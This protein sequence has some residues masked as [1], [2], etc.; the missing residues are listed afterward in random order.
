MGINIIILYILAASAPV[1]HAYQ[2]LPDPSL[3]TPIAPSLIHRLYHN[4]IVY[5]EYYSFIGVQ[6][7]FPLDKHELYD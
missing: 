2:F 1:A 3:V 4:T 7:H 5:N 6:L